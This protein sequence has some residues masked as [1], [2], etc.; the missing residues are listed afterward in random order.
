MIQV[1]NLTK[2]LHRTPPAPLGAPARPKGY[3]AKGRQ[4][5]SWWG[6]A[7]EFQDH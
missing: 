5:G 7:G 3:Q 6:G 4:R 2:S 1:R